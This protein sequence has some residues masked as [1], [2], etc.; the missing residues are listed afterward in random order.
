[1]K[2]IVLAAVLGLAPLS[3]SADIVYIAL[4]ASSYNYSEEVTVASSEYEAESDGNAFLFTVGTDLGQNLSV[5]A[6]AGAGLTNSEVDISGIN[7]TVKLKIDSIFGAYG[8][9]KT[10]IS[11]SAEVF[12]K[13]GVAKLTATASGSGKA[14]STDSSLS[15]GFGIDFYHSR[16]AGIRFEYM[17][18]YDKGLTKIDSV[19]IHYKKYM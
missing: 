17:N 8:V 2:K 16:N 9:L 12:A 18:Y 10:P 1:M 11:N 13:V 3:A 7:Q 14:D 4:G 6:V 5:E 15:Y 19:N